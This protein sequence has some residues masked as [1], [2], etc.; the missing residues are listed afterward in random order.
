ME[1]WYKARQFGAFLII[2]EDNLSC[3]A[4]LSLGPLLNMFYVAVKIAVNQR[5]FF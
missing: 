2:Q 3:L 4:Q 5:P 1:M